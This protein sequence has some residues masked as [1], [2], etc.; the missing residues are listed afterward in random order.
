V[1]DLRGSLAKAR[2]RKW[3]PRVDDSVAGKNEGLAREATRTSDAGNGCPGADGTYPRPQGARLAALG[4][5]PTEAQLA[6][7]HAPGQPQTPD[8]YWEAEWLRMRQRAN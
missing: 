8:P 2:E 4:P 5:H 3:E 6:G 7:F 1:R